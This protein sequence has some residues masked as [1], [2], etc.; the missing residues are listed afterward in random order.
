[1][2]AEVAVTLEAR[3]GASAARL[4]RW[5]RAHAP[6]CA[7]FTLGVLLRLSMMRRWDPS[8]GYDAGVYWDIVQWVVDH[9]SPFPPLDKFVCAHHPPLFFAVAAW[10]TRLGVSRQGVVLFPVLCGVVRLGLLWIGLEWYLPSRRW[11]RIFTLGLAAVLPVS[12]HIDGSLYPEPV[13]GMFAAAVMLFVPRVFAANGRRRWT[14]AA[15]VGVLLGLQMLTKITAL[16]MLLALALT[17]AIELWFSRPRGVPAWDTYVRRRAPWLLA[18]LLGASLSGW[19][20]VRNLGP[21]HKLFVTAYDTTDKAKV[22]PLANTPVLDRRTLGFFVGWDTDIYRFPYYPTGIEDHPRFFPV[23][24]ASTFVDYYNQSFSGL[25]PWGPATLK[26]NRHVLTPE[27]VSTAR[28]SM[29]GGTALFLAMVAAWLVCTKRALD[30]RAWG[31]VYLLAVP[32]VTTALDL[33]TVTQYPFDSGGVIKGAYMQF[34]APPLYAMCG[35]AF[36]W[37][38]TR[39]PFVPIAAI[40]VASV[41]FVATYTIYCRTQVLILPALGRWYVPG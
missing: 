7:L 26:A 25:D 38:R 8:W 1:M 5:L 32:L 6:E 21:Y 14:L 17:L 41:F 22:A 12:V 10:L 4:L 9:H 36:D 31:I 20:F 28:F 40:L 33:Y 37:A 11:A 16:V 27:L 19:Y 35:L 18:V 23:T 30:R 24:I 3:L 2:P 29:L 13:N 34:G 15:V 39:K